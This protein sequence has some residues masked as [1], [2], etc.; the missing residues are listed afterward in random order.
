[1]FVGPLIFVSLCLFKNL[2]SKDCNSYNCGI[3]R[4]F[5]YAQPTNMQYRIILTK[6]LNIEEI[7]LV[8]I[9]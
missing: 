9:R 4:Y 1:M 8:N 5:L 3:L 7:V 6:K 2:D